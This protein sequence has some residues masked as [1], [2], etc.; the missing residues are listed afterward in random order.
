MSAETTVGIVQICT[1]ADVDPVRLALTR[2]LLP[3]VADGGR[4][5]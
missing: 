3:S 5:R 1:N 2:T 4:F